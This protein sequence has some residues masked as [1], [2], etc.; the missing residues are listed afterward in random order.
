LHIYVQLAWTE[1]EDRALLEEA[2]KQPQNK[3]DWQKVLNI[4]NLPF[5]KLD[6]YCLSKCFVLIVINISMI[7]KVSEALILRFGKKKRTVFRWPIN[8]KRRYFEL[9]KENDQLRT[10]SHS[11]GA[12]STRISFLC[13]DEVLNEI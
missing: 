2:M 11:Q 3:K 13:T 7:D 10:S 4:R 9:L 1:C 8:C 6:G 12:Q 5:Q